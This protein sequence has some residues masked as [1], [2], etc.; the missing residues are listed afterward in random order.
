M[1]QDWG[2][3]AC[4]IGEQ[5]VAALWGLANWDDETYEDSE[6]AMEG[7]GVRILDV[8]TTVRSPHSRWPM[9]GADDRVVEI[10]SDGSRLYVAAISGTT[11]WD[12]AS[13]TQ[14]LALPGFAGR[15]HDPI[16]GMIFAIESDRISALQ[17][18]WRGVTY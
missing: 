16:R 6:G 1:R 15:L 18:P 7:P 10:F 8:T 17:L 9:A 2:P 3:P 11:V 5:H 13:R 12:I 4:W 14:T